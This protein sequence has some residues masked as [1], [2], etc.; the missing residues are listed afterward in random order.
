MINKLLSFFGLTQ[1][2]ILCLIIPA[3]C[4]LDSERFFHDYCANKLPHDI[5][6]RLP[7]GNIFDIKY[8]N[9]YL[10]E[11]EY[12]SYFAKTFAGENND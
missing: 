6:I 9:V 10:T 4:D 12:A 1:V 5:M 3:D 11:K 8:K 2:R 7:G